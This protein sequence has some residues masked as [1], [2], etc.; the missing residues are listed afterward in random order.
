MSYAEGETWAGVRVEDRK[1]TPVEAEVIRR[2]FASHPTANLS[3]G[4]DPET[5][6]HLPECL[7]AP[8]AL[9]PLQDI[10]QGDDD[11]AT[12]VTG[13]PQSATVL[14]M[15]MLAAGGLAAVTDE[16]AAARKLTA[17]HSHEHAE[18]K[19]LLEANDWLDEARGKALTVTLSLLPAL[20]Q[21]CRYRV[22]MMLP[23]PTEVTAAHARRSVQ[24]SEDKVSDY[25]ILL[26]KN[27]QQLRSIGDVLDA[28]E[29]PLLFLS[30]AD[31]TCDPLGA[32]HRIASFLELDLDISAMAG[33][34]DLNR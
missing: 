2:L 23:D 34:V 9:A 16:Q 28:H 29:I 4:F 11:F 19:S 3:A 31:V 8:L 33:V 15:A 13:L 6:P 30:Y 24:F 21:A 22:L 5:C 32:A 1:I 27:L 12:I 10:D 26:A 18:A 7:I 25:D 14:L 20:P 17:S